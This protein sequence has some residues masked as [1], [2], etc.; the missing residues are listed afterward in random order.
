M[1]R[2]VLCALLA[3]L[4]LWLAGST[5]VMGQG[6]AGASAVLR[7][8]GSKLVGTALFTEVPGGV[9]VAARVQGLAPGGHGIHLHAVGQ[10]DGPDFAS[11]GAHVNPTNAQHGLL[12]PN[13]PHAGDLPQLSVGPTGA[14]TYSAMATMIS[15]GTDARSLFDAD[16]SSLVIHAGPDDQRT[17]PVGNSGAR[18][19]CGIIVRGAVAVPSIAVPSGGLPATGD[20]SRS[21][22][23]GTSAG[24]GHGALP[25]GAALGLVILGLILPA[26]IAAIRSHRRAARSAAS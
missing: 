4:A 8:A 24:P 16:R 10:C 17:D 25:V 23:S 21:P 13:G 14:A 22:N 20:G 19:A 5:A 1:T 15:L 26:N 6:T 7:D 18:I 11:A 2:R 3:A 12:N 9:R